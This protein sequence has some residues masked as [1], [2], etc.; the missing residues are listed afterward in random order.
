MVLRKKY[1][2][3]VFKYCLSQ[4][5]TPLR[6]VG[7]DF[8]TVPRVFRFIYSYTIQFNSNISLNKMYKFN[9]PISQL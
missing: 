9:Y 4:I 2:Y 5:N 8:G 6:G 3:H 7:I 1:E